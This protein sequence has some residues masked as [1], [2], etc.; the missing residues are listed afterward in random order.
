MS[1]TN[2]DEIRHKVLD[3]VREKMSED[4]VPANLCPKDENGVEVLAVVLEDAAVDGYD[5]TGEFFFLPDTTEDTQFLVSLITIAEE[6]REETI[7]ELCIAVS[8]INT[9]M[10]I[11][12][13]SIDFLSRNLIFK[14][15]YEIPLDLDEEKLQER[16][17]LAMGTALQTVG[18]FGYILAEVNDGYRSG[19]SV[20]QIFA[21]IE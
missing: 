4:L 21:P 9:Y 12:A 20:L 3:T 16:A 7:N 14:H 17:E 11:E 13:F 18:E 2:L 6:L 10:P 8:G 19:E 5:A 15:T 1:T